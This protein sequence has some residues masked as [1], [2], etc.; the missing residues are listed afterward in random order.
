VAAVLHVEQLEVGYRR[1]PILP[2]I[3]FAIEN[4]ELWALVG[5]NGAGKATPLPTLLGLLPQVRGTVTWKPD[6]RIGYVPQRSE[7]D[8]TVP[9]RA[10]DVVALGL[11][12]AWSFMR[13]LKRRD[14]VRAVL[15]EV[16]MEHLVDQPFVAMSDGQRQRVLVA[17][18]LASD[19]DVLILD[20]PTNGMDLAAERAAFDLFAKL[21]SA[22]K[23]ALIVVSHRVSMLGARASH[24]LWVDKDEGHVV[25]GDVDVVRHHPSFI[26]H[27]GAAFGDA[28]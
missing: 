1:Q 15:A 27:Y 8:L 5:R 10:R 25:A 18:A 11:D 14:H 17:R 22:R 20:E 16:G 6:V 3:S 13:P 4:E 21:K 26:A 2:S 28:A 9:A 19:P 7:I 12:A 24:I 23:L